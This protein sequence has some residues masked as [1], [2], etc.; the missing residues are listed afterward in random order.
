MTFSSS[1]TASSL[2]VKLWRGERMCLVGMGHRPRPRDDFVG[3]AIEVKSPGA[4]EYAPLRNRL[5][6][7]YDDPA[8]KGVD[9]F[10]QLPV[11]VGSVPEVPLDPLPLRPG[12]RHLPVQGHQDAH[13]L[14]GRAARRRPGRRLADLA[15]P[16]HLRRLSGSGLH[17]ELRL[18][19][20]LCGQ[21]RQQPKRHPSRAGHGPFLPQ[22]IRGTSMLG[23]GSR[24][25][26]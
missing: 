2:T 7:D 6:F 23:S 26:S 4:V 11:H 19:P 12:G 24:H 13:G 14:R 18:V 8:S 22:E 10:P 21:V 5:N 25:T 17:S 3:F 9:G 20:S 15:R 1:G 16:R